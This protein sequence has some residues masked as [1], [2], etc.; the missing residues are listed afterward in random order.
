MSRIKAIVRK[1]SLK[2]VF[3]KFLQ[4]SLEN[5]CARVS[6]LIKLQ[7]SFPVNFAKFLRAPLLIEY[8]RLPLLPGRL[9]NVLQFMY[10]V[11]GV[12]QRCRHVKGGDKYRMKSRFCFYFIITEIV[13]S[14][15]FM[16]IIFFSITA[17]VE[18]I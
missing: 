14:R 12:Q 10:Y 15:G 13:S 6:F 7:A 9:I 8:L 4:N 2:K 16:N 3:L 17:V 11:L 1:C 5:T 18:L